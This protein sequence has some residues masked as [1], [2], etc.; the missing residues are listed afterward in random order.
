MGVYDKAA[1][2]EEVRRLLPDVTMVGVTGSAAFEGRHFTPDSDIDIIAVGHRNCFAWGQA[3]GHELEIRVYTRDAMERPLQNPQWHPTNWIFL[4]GKIAGAEVLVGDSPRNFVLSCMSDRNRL[5]AGSA[6]LGFLLLYDIKRKARRRPPSLDAPLI[7]TGLRHVVAR[8]LPMRAEP[9]EA[10]RHLSPETD[11]SKM[12]AFAAEL[13]EQ[14]RDILADDEQVAS[15]M[16]LPENR[17]G[18]HWLRN[19]IGIHREMPNICIF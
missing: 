1:V 7:L 19:A 6:L 12:V 10:F 4:A 9:E 15:M 17:T 5:I 3:D 13:A 14:S 18:L 16:Y 8:N 2:L 11:L